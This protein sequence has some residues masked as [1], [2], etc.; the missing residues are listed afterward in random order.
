MDGVLYLKI[1]AHKVEL[2]M[3]IIF[4]VIFNI[5]SPVFLNY[6]K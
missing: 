4:I 3:S 1:I 2:S 5:D 6:D